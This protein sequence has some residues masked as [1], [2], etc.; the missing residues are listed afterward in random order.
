MINGPQKFCEQLRTCLAAAPVR[1]QHIFDA[2]LL[3][4]CATI[5]VFVVVVVVVIVL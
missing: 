1:M 3:V 5:V 4:S 2:A